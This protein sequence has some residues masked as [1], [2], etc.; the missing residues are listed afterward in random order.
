M[1][2]VTSALISSSIFLA[3]SAAGAAS[4]DIHLGITRSL[5]LT[6]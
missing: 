3:M 2:K 4:N 1:N 6:S 5:S